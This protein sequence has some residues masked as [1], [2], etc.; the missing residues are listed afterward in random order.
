MNDREVA[1]ILGAF[2]SAGLSTDD[3]VKKAIENGLK[4]V[5]RE[6]YHD[7]HKNNEKNYMEAICK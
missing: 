4:Q 7:R 2:K 6:K 3:A 1:I 5:R